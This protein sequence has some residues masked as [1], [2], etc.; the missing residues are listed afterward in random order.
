MAEQRAARDGHTLGMIQIHT[1]VFLFGFAG[2]FGKFLTCSPL[3]IVLGRT[4]FGGAALWI[5]ARLVSDTR[6]GGFGKTDL[7][8]F[9]LQ[10]ILLA[11]HWVLFFL[12]IQVSSVAVG[13]VTF[14]S[15]P[16]FV[17][18]MEPL[19][20]RERLKPADV[21]TALA[22]FAGIILVVPEIDLSN[23]VTL[24]AVYGVLS[25]LTFAILGLVNRRNVRGGD[26]VAVAF[27]QNAFAALFLTLPVLI[28][29]PEPP[30]LAALPKLMALGV[31]FTA[32]AHTCFIRSLAVIRVQT[33]SV[34]AGL[35]PVYG[36]IFAFLL[37][38]EI[39]AASTLAGG[40]LII[41]ATIVAG[42]LSRR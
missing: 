16:L 14:S 42:I 20:F 28:T 3:Y 13:L 38:K 35:E 31:I 5:Y 10:G 4:L 2:L 25:G 11:A 33:A 41:G 17:T 29:A 1:A 21:A 23:R 34:I 18:F 9:T 15:F 8:F 32:L 30:G 40:G 6:L 36:I 26:A 22:V 12:S 27:Y 24:G 19:F 7:L 37:L 39:P